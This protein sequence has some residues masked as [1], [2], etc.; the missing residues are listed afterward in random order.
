MMIVSQMTGL[1][2]FRTFSLVTACVALSICARP[3]A[4]QVVRI[5]DH[6][7]EFPTADSTAAILPA[8]A[9]S[10]AASYGPE[11]TYGSLDPYGSAD[12]YGN[13]TQI[14]LSYNAGDGVA[15]KQSF[16]S[17]GFLKPILSSYDDD[18]S[19]TSIYLDTRFVIQNDSNVAG[20]FGMVYREYFPDQQ[21]IWGINFFFDVDDTRHGGTFNQ[22]GFGLE[23][24]GEVVDFRLNGYFPFGNEIKTL[25]HTPIMST[26][27][28]GGMSTL[29][30]RSRFQQSAL[31]GFDLEIGALLSG[32]F[33][34]DHDVRA[35]VGVYQFDS[36]TGPNVTG[37]S[38]RIQGYVAK[39]TLLQLSLTDDDEFNTNLI[40]SVVLEL[41]R[42]FGAPSPYEGELVE[43]LASQRVIRNQ[44]VVATQ[45]TDF[46]PVL[47][48]T[49]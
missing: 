16:T 5:G 9:Y 32:H 40:V 30:F 34:S 42:F 44:T 2:R 26:P 27:I 11:E 17:L 39:N 14:W 36:N 20:N 15:N 4:G 25:G 24:L 47:I 12:A 19:A 23:S 28:N 8:D 46:D 7:A 45:R 48:T 49:P 22:V 3:C 33:A 21:R 43:R 31:T 13:G 18:G 6:T 1:W 37:F 41:S 38:T 29:F 35:F 10:P